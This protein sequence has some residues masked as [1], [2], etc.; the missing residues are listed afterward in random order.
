MR[1]QAEEAEFARISGLSG[2][3]VHDSTPAT[4]AFARQRLHDRDSLRSSE[5][6][7][8]VRQEEV[9]LA[10]VMEL[11]HLRLRSPVFTK[12]LLAW[13][14]VEFYERQT[15]EDWMQRFKGKMSDADFAIL[16]SKV[17]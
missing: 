8:N 11:Y 10:E 5:Q 12:A 17:F 13:E 3:G 15:D 14:R 4:R 16:V 2:G 1:R 9:P 6:A 7:Y